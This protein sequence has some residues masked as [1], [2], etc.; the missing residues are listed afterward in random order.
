MVLHRA[1]DRKK[2]VIK[3]KGFVGSGKKIE[4]IRKVVDFIGLTIT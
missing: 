2:R 3:L 4:R 1:R